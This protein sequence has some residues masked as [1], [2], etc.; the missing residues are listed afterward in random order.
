MMARRLHRA[1][2]EVRR[3][4]RLENALTA[5]ITQASMPDSGGSLDELILAA[6]ETADAELDRNPNH[7]SKSSGSIH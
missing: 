1:I 5:H 2:D 7:G 3:E 4:L 6:K